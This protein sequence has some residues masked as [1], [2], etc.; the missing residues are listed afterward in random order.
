[1]SWKHD[2]AAARRPWRGPVEKYDLIKEGLIALVV[3]ALLLV[4]LSTLL[5]S[6]KLAAMNFKMWANNAPA[7]FVATTLS[8]LNGTS[9]TATYGPPYNNGAGSLQYLGPI[10]FQKLGGIHFPVDAANDLV[11]K[12]LTALAPLNP[13][14]QQALDQ[15]KGATAAQRAA[16]N[17]ASQKAKV[18]VDGTTVKLEGGDTG[19]IPTL[20]GAMLAAGRSGALDGQLIDAPGGLAPYTM[21]YTKSLLFLEDSNYMGEIAAQY[22][23]QGQRWGVMNEIGNWP[24]QPWLWFYSGFYQIP[25]WV[26]YSQ[27]SDIIV[28]AT[29][30]VLVGILLFLPFIPGLRSLPRWI[31]L[32]RLVWRDYYRKYGR[33][34]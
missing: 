8:E 26:N 27:G 17:A 21:N 23:L 28:I 1:M 14:L 34:P 22:T 15:W 7:D 5:G 13:A 31:G 33:T 9:E 10:S 25:P 2:H 3:V 6:P 18:V 29:V 11:I 19:P 16:W 30:V 12:P 32:Y 4:V 24:G 20:L